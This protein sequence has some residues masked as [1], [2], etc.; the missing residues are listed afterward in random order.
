MK[1]KNLIHRQVGCKSDKRSDK[2]NDNKSDKRN[3][4][5]S[6]IIRALRKVIKGMVIK[7]VIIEVIT[8]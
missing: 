2:R 6:L 4:N 8:S 3:D 1:E 5:K 7:G